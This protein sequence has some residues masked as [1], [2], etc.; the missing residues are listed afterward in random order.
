[1]IGQ[2]L[3]APH[4]G[5]PPLDTAGPPLSVYEFWPMQ[6]FYLPIFAHV[7]WLMLRHRSITLPTAANPSFPGGGFYGESKAEILALVAQGLNN[8]RSIFVDR[9]HGSPIGLRN[10][11]SHP[12]VDESLHHLRHHTGDGR[13]FDDLSWHL[14]LEGTKNPPIDIKLSLL[15]VTNEN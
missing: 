4:E 5:M 7:L 11:T 14:R 10:T 6:V 3:A 15:C 12:V 8:F 13:N 9:H 1:M 2:T